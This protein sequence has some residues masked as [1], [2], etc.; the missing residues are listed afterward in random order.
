[1]LAKY[2]LFSLLRAGKGLKLRL[3]VLLKTVL[4]QTLA[5]EKR[6]SGLFLVLVEQFVL[7]LHPVGGSC[8]GG[9]YRVG[10]FVR[11]RL[12]YRLFTLALG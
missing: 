9:G 12:F 7:S 4:L 2:R 11:G 5:L 8:A 6:A 1:M 10:A 3:L